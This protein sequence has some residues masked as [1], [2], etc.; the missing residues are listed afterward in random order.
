MNTVCIVGRFTSD[1]ELRCTESGTKVTTFSLAVPRG[2][3]QEAKIDFFDCVAWRGTAEFIDKYFH[4][5]QLCAVF[6]RL[7]SRTWVSQEGQNR[8]AIEIVVSGIDFCGGKNQQQQ[9]QDT[10]NVLPAM[11][12]QD[13]SDTDDGNLP[14]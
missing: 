14:F 2:Y 1:P 9:Q 6:G 7:Q 13:I 11:E 12:F 8:K 3:N 5:G 10:I 4:K